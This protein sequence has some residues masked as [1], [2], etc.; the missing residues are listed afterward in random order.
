MKSDG[1]WR[2]VASMGFLLLS[3]PWLSSFLSL[4]NLSLD[5]DHV[6]DLCD[7]CS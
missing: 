5:V 3:F 4:S 6:H 7:T 2:L 1:V